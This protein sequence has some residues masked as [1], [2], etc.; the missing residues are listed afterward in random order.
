MKWA[1]PL[2]I[3]GVSLLVGAYAADPTT[4]VYTTT[5]FTTLP[6]DTVLALLGN[7]HLQ[8]MRIPTEPM[9]GCNGGSRTQPDMG[10]E[11]DCVRFALDHPSIHDHRVLLDDM[12]ALFRGCGVYA[13]S[14]SDTWGDERSGESC[15]YLGTLFYAVGNV[16]A[17]KAVWESAP[18]CHSHDINNSP[19]NGCIRFIAKDVDLPKGWFAQQNEGPWHAYD[20]EP[21][22]LFAMADKACAQELD[23]NACSY[24][25]QHGK[26]V[27]WALVNAA[28]KTR[29]DAWYAQIQANQEE[30]REKA[31]ERNDLR[32]AVIGALQGMPGATDPNAIVNAARNSFNPALV[33]G[34]RV[35]QAAALVPQLPAYRPAQSANYG[36]AQLSGVAATGTAALAPSDLPATNGPS[37][38]TP[39]PSSCVRQY[40]D[41]QYYN[42]LS[43][44][45]DCGRPIR[46]TFIFNHPQGVAMTGAIDLAP[47]AHDNTG[48]SKADID[49]AG[50]FVLYVCPPS[51]S[52]ADLNGNILENTNVS[53]YR[54]RVEQ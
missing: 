33:T 22:K 53:Q 21:E 27:N 14:E 13:H 4:A 29:Q 3:L 7:A 40:W 47:G 31:R 1:L 12:K 5:D 20:S 11:F 52:P 17:A 19:I 16:P 26:M 37:Y 45:N 30:R 2:T 25:D 54:C 51:G 39:L 10:P 15:G 48:R 18:G 6:Q 28:I 43:F 36:E 32:D 50:G 42:W 46:L 35:Y 41:P 34:Q 23:A 8:A 49:S 9:R 44:E 24:V 38:V